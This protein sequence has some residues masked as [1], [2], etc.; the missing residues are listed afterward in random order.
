MI[1]IGLPT[2]IN[3]AIL[4]FERMDGLDDVFGN[5]ADK[6]LLDFPE[7]DLQENDDFWCVFL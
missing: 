6:F 1:S 2:K 4:K 3:Q 7:I 5:E